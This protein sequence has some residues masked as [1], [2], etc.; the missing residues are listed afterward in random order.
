MSI[1]T[2]Q[3]NRFNCNRKKSANNFL[4]TK[5]LITSQSF[6]SN[7]KIL[8]LLSLFDKSARSVAVVLISIY[9]RYIS[10]RKGYSCAHRIVYGGMSCSEYVKNTLTDKSMFESILLA[11][12]RFKACKI[13]HKSYKSGV[14]GPDACDPEIGLACCGAIVGCH[15]LRRR[16]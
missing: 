10:P 7:F 1:F 13:A 8:D 5:N 16:E 14:V 6:I 12:Q 9:Q 15:L 3:S 4:G 11:Q 2:Q